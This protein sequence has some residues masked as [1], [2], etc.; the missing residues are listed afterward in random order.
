ML[1]LFSTLL[2]SLVSIPAFA[3]INIESLRQI[4]GKGYLGQTTLQVAG[5]QG[6]TD[7][8]TSQAST[9]GVYRLDVNEWLYTAS[10]QYGTSA[11]VKD[12]NLGSGHIRHTWNYQEPLAYEAFA[13]SAFDEFKKLNSQNYAGGNLRFRIYHGEGNRLYAGVGAF[14]EVEDF[15]GQDEDAEGVRGNLYISH[16]ARLNETVT[17]STVIY[18]QPKF[19]DIANY[20]LR[21]MTG[22]DVRMTKSLSLD[23]DFNLVNDS[24][25]PEGVKQTDIDYLVGFSVKY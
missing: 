4:D 1:K 8:F 20:R 11:N 12:T 17:S 21:L 18:Y 13:Q 3:F 9:M 10:Y 7:K 14:Y 23:I 24:G 16:V 15:E 19:N 5:Q 6:N 2:F 22:L 25:L